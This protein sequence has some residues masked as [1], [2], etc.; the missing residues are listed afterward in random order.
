LL[1]K[2][3]L[4]SIKLLYISNKCNSI[5]TL[6]HLLVSDSIG[7]P[8]LIKLIRQE[9]A[10]ARILK[11]RTIEDLFLSDL[12]PEQKKEYGQLT[13]GIFPIS[14]ECQKL[15]DKRIAEFNP[16]GKTLDM[17]K[18]VFIKNCSMCH[19]ID[20]KGGLIGPQLDGIGTWGRQSLTTKILDPNRNITENFRMYNITLKNGKMVSGLYRRDEGQSMILADVTGKEFSIPQQNIQE[21]VASPYT[22]M[23]DSFSTT[24]SKEDVDALLVFLLHEK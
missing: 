7:K 18:A 15:I 10:P 17:G 8:Q 24:I 12:Q 3:K 14:E 2:N 11:S 16:T 9:E 21:K 20:K 19:Q 13:A 22:L 5:Q 23:P 1:W 6:A 4:I